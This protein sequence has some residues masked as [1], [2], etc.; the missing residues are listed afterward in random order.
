MDDSDWYPV[1]T[2]NIVNREQE[3]NCEEECTYMWYEDANHEQVLK[4]YPAAVQS[5]LSRWHH[6]RSYQSWHLQWQTTTTIIM[7]APLNQEWLTHQLVTLPIKA[8]LFNLSA[9]YLIC[10]GRQHARRWPRCELS[11]WLDSQTLLSLHL[12]QIRKHTQLTSSE[13]TNN[14]DKLIMWGEHQRIIRQNS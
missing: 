13:K 5:A 3:A 11:E 6:A 9:A 7:C 4:R 2:R 14:F 1:N 8:L 10:W 12:Q